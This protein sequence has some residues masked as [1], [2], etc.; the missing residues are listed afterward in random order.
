MRKAVVQGVMGPNET[1][2]M[3]MYSWRL[4]ISYH[5]SQGGAGFPAKENV[6]KFLNGLKIDRFI[7][8]NFIAYNHLV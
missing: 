6:I 3:G 7:A 4:N 2:E 8:F 5:S 1:P